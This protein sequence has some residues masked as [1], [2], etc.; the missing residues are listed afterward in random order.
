MSDEELYRK[1]VDELT[2]FATGLVGPFDA[3]DVVIDAWVSSSQATQWRGA[4][5]KRSYLY[6]AVLNTAR[7]HHR[8][9]LARR[10]REHRAALPD[11]IDI[12]ESDLDV[13]DAVGRLSMRQRAVVWFTYWEGHTTSEVA[14]ILALS[15]GSVKRHLARARSRL[16]ELLQ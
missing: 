10:L 2:R 1:H 13:L 5:N 16:R 11:R 15:E 4:E 3:P 9:T 6:R 8:S 12:D 14:E 7:S